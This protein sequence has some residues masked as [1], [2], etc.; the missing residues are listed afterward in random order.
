MTN[1]KKY[2]FLI[3]SCLF[4]LALIIVN[5]NNSFFWD[6]VHYGS[7]VPDF[8]Y[9]SHFKSILLPDGIDSG[10]VP[11]F[12]LYIAAIWTLF[13]RTLAI[14]HFA[15]LPFVFGILY[16]LYKISHRFFKNEFTNLVM[17][18][19]LADTTLLS[20]FTLVSPDLPLLFFFL[21]GLNSIL[22]NRKFFIAISVLFLFM[23][24]TR[25]IMLS[26][27]LL[28]LDI[29][30]IISQ[31]KKGKKVLF[32]LFKRSVIYLPGF[33]A[34][35]LYNY[36]HFIQKGWILSH[37]D[38][39]WKDTKAMVDGYGLLFNIA[40]LCWRLIDFGKVMIWIVLLFL[41]ISLKKQFLNRPES[42]SLL[43][44][45]ICLLMFVHIDLIWANNL[46]AHR[47]FM[48]FHI[49]LTLF[50]TS[51]LFADL[52]SNKMKYT[53]TFLMLISLISGSFLI[54][55]NKIAKGWDATLA[56]LPYYDLRHQAIT[57]IDNEQINFKD[58]QSFFPNTASLDQIDLN[59]D[60]RNFNNYNGKSEYVFYSNIYNITDE[61]YDEIHN[62][63]YF[64]SIQH[65]ESKDVF[66]TIYKKIK[67]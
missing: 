34:F 9:T 39:P 33:F 30:L 57:Y 7:I 1:T 64:K 24:I 66:I 16:Q 48:P 15:M 10:E 4:T 58:V 17:L 44:L 8:Y 52:I 43:F 3:L 28:L 29:N 53:A 2:Y 61:E 65:F 21:L 32:E 56:H 5:S 12:S 63:I 14:S 26:F 23:N 46:L 13:G 11:V 49:I 25:G 35:L 37:Q 6:G 60:H 59:G 18:L 38:S 42:K 55:P 36:Y 51:I 45:L 67:P 31:M 50:C 62:T 22:G 40:L 27:C 54:Y 41:L 19:F 47:Y 20:Q